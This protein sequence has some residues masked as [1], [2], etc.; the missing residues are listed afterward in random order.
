[1]CMK[2]MIYICYVYIYNQADDLNAL[3]NVQIPDIIGF[4]FQNDIALYSPYY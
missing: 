4:F 3:S 1:M 2:R